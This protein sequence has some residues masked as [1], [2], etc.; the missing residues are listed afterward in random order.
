MRRIVLAMHGETMLYE[1]A[2]AAEVLDTSGYDF[3]VATPDGGPHPWLATRPTRS[4]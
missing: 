4:W 3:V 2:I 1:V